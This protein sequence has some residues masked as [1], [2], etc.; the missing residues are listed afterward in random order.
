ME[1]I[2]MDAV[3]MIHL[4]TILIVVAD[5]VHVLGI[6]RPHSKHQRLHAARI[7][8]CIDTPDIIPF[9]GFDAINI[10]QPIIPAAEASED[11]SHTDQH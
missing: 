7:R 9:T 4:A 6:A 2:P 10:F 5:N 3:I 11:Y 1:S 8:E